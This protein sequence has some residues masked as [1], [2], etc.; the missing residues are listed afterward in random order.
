MHINL[1]EIKLRMKST[2]KNA[3]K[4][5]YEFQHQFDIKS[6]HPPQNEEKRVPLIE[7][8]FSLTHGPDPPFREIEIF[9]L[10]K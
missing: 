6:I 4:S 10:M 5:E 2:C 9:N 7:I 1:Y 3:I 8:P